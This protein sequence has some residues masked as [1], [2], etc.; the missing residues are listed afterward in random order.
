MKKK[1]CKKFHGNWLIFRGC[2]RLSDIY[3]EGLWAYNANFDRNCV[4]GCIFYYI[5]L[6]VFK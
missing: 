2:Y 3:M 4:S 6:T 1:L 5:R